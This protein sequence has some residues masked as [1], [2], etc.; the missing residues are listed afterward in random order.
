MQFW[1]IETPDLENCPALQ[2]KQTLAPGPAYVPGGH[3]LQLPSFPSLAWNWPTGHATQQ[4]VLVSGFASNVPDMHARP[5]V[6][7]AMVKGTRARMAI[8]RK[9]NES[10]ISNPG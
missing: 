9:S 8:I 4:L 6:S 3:I 10:L 2:F 5:S 1:N 7:H